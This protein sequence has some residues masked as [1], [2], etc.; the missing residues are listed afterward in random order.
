MVPDEFQ[1]FL[2]IHGID[3]GEKLQKLFHGIPVVDVIQ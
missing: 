2:G 1:E 3:G